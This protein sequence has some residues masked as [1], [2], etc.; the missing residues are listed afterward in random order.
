MSGHMAHPT[1]AQRSQQSH[2]G[3]PRI[4][5]ATPNLNGISMNRQITQTPRLNQG[6][7]LQGPMAQVPHVN[8]QM[9]R[10]QP[11]NLNTMQISQQMAQ[12]QQQIVQQQHAATA[13]G[14]T[15]MTN[16]QQMS[17]QQFMQ[18]QQILQGQQG[19]PMTSNI[20]LSQQYAARA[21]AMAQ[22]Q[23]GMPQNMNQ[24]FVNN[25]NMANLQHMQQGHQGQ[26][27][28]PPQ[29]NQAQVMN[30]QINQQAKV[31]FNQGIQHLHADH[32]GGIPPEA[33]NNFG[34]LCN[35]KAKAQIQRAYQARRHQFQQQQMMAA[36]QGNMGQNMKGM[37]SG[38]GMQRPPG[39]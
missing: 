26:Q 33:L 8:Q 29:F 7:P 37:Q 3:T 25:G 1:G 9:M 35:Q 16:G 14:M 18:A 31:L 22:A 6:S 12:Q 15:R 30:T 20:Q 34:Q 17:P 27:Q 4:P 13:Q 39:I 5:S 19:N 21:M 28:P 38:M 11:N 10:G 36:A 32:P 2:A 23:G 24:N